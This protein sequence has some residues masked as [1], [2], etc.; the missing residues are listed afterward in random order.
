MIWFDGR[1]AYATANY[2]VQQLYS[3]Y[4]GNIILRAEAEEKEFYVSASEREGLTFVKV[5]NASGREVSAEFEG[6][7]DFGGIIRI[8]RMEGEPGD[9]NTIRDPGK[10][11]PVE[12]APEAARAAVLPPHSFSVFVF[13]R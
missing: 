4:T 12:I 11:S 1:S 9:Y 3:L 6:D 5:V 13:R 10:I 2:Y 8:I 7:F